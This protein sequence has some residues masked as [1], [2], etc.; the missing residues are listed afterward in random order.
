MKTKYAEQTACKQTSRRRATHLHVCIYLHCCDVDHNAMTLR[1][2][3]DTDI[4]KMYQHK[5]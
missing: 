4:L 3:H 2:D 5:K 1:L